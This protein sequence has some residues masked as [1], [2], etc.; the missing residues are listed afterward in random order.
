MNRTNKRLCACIALLVLNL[1]VIWGNSLL[2]GYIS[3]SISGFVR[4]KLLFFIPAVDVEGA[5]YGGEGLLRKIAHFTEFACLGFLLSWLVR[6]CNK[7]IICHLFLPLCAGVLVA[8]TDEA[9]QRFIP[10]RSCRLFD[11]GIDTL[12]VVTGIVIISLLQMKNKKIN[13]ME[14][15]KQ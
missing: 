11:V 6:M 2:P 10:G 12:G 15:T 8:V 14:E 9:I 1:T 13:N 4:E 5:V 3:S 7:E